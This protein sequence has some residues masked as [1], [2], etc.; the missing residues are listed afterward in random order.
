ML[1]SADKIAFSSRASRVKE[2]NVE[3][4]EIW[5]IW[6][7]PNG[8]AASHHDVI[9]LIRTNMCQWAFQSDFIIKK[10]NFKSFFCKK[11]CFAPHKI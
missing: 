7:T 6:S 5:Y 3:H 9:A 4:D 10:S 11:L 8:N 2:S 1:H